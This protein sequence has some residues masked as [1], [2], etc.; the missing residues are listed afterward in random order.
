MIS[1]LDNK[2]VKE[3]TKL[4]LKKYRTDEFLLLNEEL[5][6]KAKEEG[7]LKKL[8][9]VGEKPFE[10][11]EA[12]EV[13][14]EVLNKISKDEPNIN[15]L[16]V[17]SFIKDSS[18]YSN[19]IIILDHLQDPLNIGR[20]ME[21]AYTFHFDTIIISQDSADIYNEKCLK[22]SKGAIYKLNIHHANLHDEICKLKQDGYLVYATGLR[23][24]TKELLEVKPS[25]KM[26]FV[27]GNEGSGV[28]KE[29]MDISNDI[30]KIDM[31]NIDSLNVA[32]AAAIVMYQFSI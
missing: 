23:D 27:L 32:M 24:N 16:G 6:I 15:Y 20:I 26:A 9:Y 8:I 17:S 22:A 28:T 14:R 13:S 18:N 5:V 25:E 7:Y 3:L 30:M 4:H 29:V 19:R 12:I 31:R 2:M 11:N 1:S 10:F 21:A